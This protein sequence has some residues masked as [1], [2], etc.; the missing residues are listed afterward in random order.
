MAKQDDDD[1][2]DVE[3]GDETAADDS[4]FSVSFDFMGTPS[5][6][7]SELL[8]NRSKLQLQQQQ[9]PCSNKQCRKEKD[10]L[11]RD[12]KGKYLQLM[13]LKK[14]NDRLSALKLEEATKFNAA[15]VCT[16]SIASH[17]VMVPDLSALHSHSL[18]LCCSFID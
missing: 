15:L 11:M 2:D 10:Q 4:G 9:V 17:H 5:D 3:E 8:K 6:S 14:E 12:V 18:L 13:E 7:P 16:I 1:E